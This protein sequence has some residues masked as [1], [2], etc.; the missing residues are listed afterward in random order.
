MYNRKLYISCKSW[1]DIFS[2]QYCSQSSLFELG[3]RAGRCVDI[4]D[5][6]CVAAK[7]EAIGIIAAATIEKQ[8]KKT[9]KSIWKHLCFF[10]GFMYLGNK[11]CLSGNPHSSCVGTMTMYQFL[12][13]CEC[14]TFCKF[15][16]SSEVSPSW[17]EC[18]AHSL[19]YSFQSPHC[20]T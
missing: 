11:N 6:Y 10:R 14:I 8:K 12:Q 3:L 9:G 15:F 13:F 1:S 20:S 17:W 16:F 2:Y 7:I 4:C 5:E 18:L 19:F